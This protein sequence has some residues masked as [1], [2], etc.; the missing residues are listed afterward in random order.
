MD[1]Y[2]PLK[3]RGRNKNNE[4][5]AGIELFYTI[6]THELKTWSEYF[7]SM[8]LEEKNFEVRKNDRNFKVGNYLLL[9]EWNPESE[10]YTGREVFRKIEY[11]L[12]GGQFGI[13]EGYIVM[14]L[15][16]ILFYNNEFENLNTRSKQ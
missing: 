15:S 1:R 14:G 11:I 10:E 13:E 5:S 3:Y 12:K 9:K 4:K 8:V 7:E 6:R 16:D 2:S